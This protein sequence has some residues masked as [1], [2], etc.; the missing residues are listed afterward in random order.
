[1]L[2]FPWKAALD[3]GPEADAEAAATIRNGAGR[4]ALKGTLGGALDGTM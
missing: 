2:D 1:M 4:K 3:A